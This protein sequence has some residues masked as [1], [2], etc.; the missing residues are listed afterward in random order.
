MTTRD[1][2]LLPLLISEL[3]RHLVTLEDDASRTE[4]NEPVRR[5]VHALKGSAGLA[6]E[7]ELSQ[8][9]ARLER[10]LREG[11]PLARRETADVVR[12]AV[13]RLARGESAIAASWPEPPNGLLRMLDPTMRSQYVSEITDRIAQID[14]ALSSYDD[15][16]ASATEIY[17][18]IHTIKGA[19]SAVG[20]EP[21]SW[22]CHGLEERL[23]P[24]SQR[25]SCSLP[26]NHFAAPAWVSLR[27]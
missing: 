26:S 17:R 21:M 18:H 14:R 1:P 23:R 4:H 15:P 9:L 8:A 25:C 5:A 6:G 12:T 20:D 22:F 2:E 24:G 7:P 19:A 3:K 10:R 16:I 13:L 11:D 27:R